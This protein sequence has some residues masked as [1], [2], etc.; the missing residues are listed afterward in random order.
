MGKFAKT[1]AKVGATLGYFTGLSLSIWAADEENPVSSYS[2]KSAQIHQLNSDSVAATFGVFNTACTA[3]GA[4]GG[5]MIGGML[6]CCCGT[7]EEPE[8]PSFHRLNR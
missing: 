7:N 8:L 2:K 1:G 4:I 6:D 3:A 5:T